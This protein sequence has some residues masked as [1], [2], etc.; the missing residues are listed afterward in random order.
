MLESDVLT[1]ARNLVLGGFEALFEDLN[2]L[3]RYKGRSN[4]M[5]RCVPSFFRKSSRWVGACC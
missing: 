5:G 4:S 1:C 3:V 2:P